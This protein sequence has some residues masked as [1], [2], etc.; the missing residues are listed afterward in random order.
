MK[1][2]LLLATLCPFGMLAQVTPVTDAGLPVQSIESLQQTLKLP[3]APV[4]KPTVLDDEAAER[5]R[6]AEM[7]KIAVS[8]S[9]TPLRTLVRWLAEQ[10][11]M[12]YFAL[13]GGQSG[14][15]PIT[16]N[17][18]RRPIEVLDM[19]ADSYGIGMTYKGGVWHFYQ[20][21]IH[22]LIARTYQLF[23]N[24]GEEYDSSGGGG[25]GDSSSGRNGGGNANSTNGNS[26][27]NSG[28]NS[29]GS[30]GASV[31]IKSDQA[32]K[33]V[34]TIQ[35]YLQTDSTAA[36]ATFLQTAGV[37]EFFAIPR[38]DLASSQAV[39]SASLEAGAKN[40]N[41][42]KGKVFFNSDTNQIYVLA[43]RQQHEYIE[44]LLETVDKPQKQIAVETKFIETSRDASRAFGID[45]S[46]VTNPSLSLS[47]LN[48]TVDLNKINGTQWPASAILSASDLSIGMKALAS[49]SNSTAVQYPRM[50][51]LNNR[52][53]NIDSTVTR[54][55]LSATTSTSA[56]GAISGTQTIQ[57]VQ[58]E[59][60]G[61]IVSILPKVLS[62]ADGDNVLLNIEVE[63]SSFSGQT[64]IQDVAYP[65][66]SIRRFSYQVIVR[67]GYTLAIGGL[68]ETVDSTSESKI[69]GL[70]DI[71]FFGLAFKNKNPTRS[72]HSL[73][74]LVTP[75]IMTG[76]TGGLPSRPIST[77]PRI[78]NVQRR[79]FLGSPEETLNDVRRSLSG[80]Q[81]EIELTSALARESRGSKNDLVKADLLLNELD[82]MSVKVRE[83]GGKTEEGQELAA[84]ISAYRKAMKR[85]RDE[86]AHSV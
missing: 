36:G 20:Q 60:V 82:L 75:T 31:R 2:L 65:N 42:S 41:L 72:K 55:V 47:K 7:P 63:V 30:S 64:T 21:N 74:M 5:R 8:F 57:S 39:A 44:G 52:Q 38:P 10:S 69:P 19:L 86:L 54:K 80:F 3:D 67:S 12:S 13:P 70:G 61:T 17:V 83:D 58:D 14:D 79:T 11:S 16:L 15:Q 76:Y 6:L 32:K 66:K 84:T 78:S 34:S 45:W 9:N 51:T 29:S 81:Q 23:Y 46:G 59:K 73:M 25:G 71:P 22:E 85:A 26:G 56:G 53:V 48:T 28:N 24:T 1:R 40:L 49:D 68:E 37:G 43:T 18:T 77:T 62:N 33:L 27:N 50:V 4:A 35:E